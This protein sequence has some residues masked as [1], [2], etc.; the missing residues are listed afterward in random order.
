MAVRAQ[1][2]RR[3]WQAGEQRRFCQAQLRRAFG[4]VTLR[5]GFDANHIAAKWR[6][7]EILRQNFRF[8]VA[9]LKL[10]RAKGFDDFGGQRARAW[11]H[12]TN[13]L[14]GERRS[15]GHAPPGNEIL[16]E[17]AGQRLHIHTGML[18]EPLVFGGDNRQVNPAARFRCVAGASVQ[19][20]RGKPHAQW[21]AGAIHQ[22]GGGRL[23]R[24]LLFGKWRPA[25][26]RIDARSQRQR[27]DDGHLPIR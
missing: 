27:R 6:T 5:G 14:H 8:A 21:H 12:Q 11:L 2:R 17:G 7:V 4:E 16:Q 13:N 22:N 10:Q 25:H 1:A 9:A 23:A 15:A 24:Q 18:P 26:A 20:A 19:I 3:L